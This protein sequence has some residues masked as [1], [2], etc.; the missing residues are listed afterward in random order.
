[1]KPEDPPPE[2]SIGPAPDDTA[3][4]DARQSRASWP[5]IQPD[6]SGLGRR[7]AWGV[8]PRCYLG[9]GSTTAIAASGRLRFESLSRS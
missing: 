3:V 6:S 8:S 4:L 2:R 7:V 1:V 9:F 5:L